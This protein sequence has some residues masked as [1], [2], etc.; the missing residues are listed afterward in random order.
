MG[1]I[2]CEKC[3]ITIQ[4]E[5][6]KDKRHIKTS[7]LRFCSKTC[8]NSNARS[9]ACKSALSE[10]MKGLVYD[11]PTKYGTVACQHCTKTVIRNYPH[12]KFCSQNCFKEYHRSVRTERENYRIACQ[13]NF[14]V[15]EYPAFFDL[16]LIN[17]HGWYAPT[18]KGNNLNGVSR[19]HRIS[20][21]EGFAKK[22]D[23]KIIAH[24]ANCR[25]VLHKENQMKHAKSSLTIEALC[26]E[27]SKF[28]L[29]G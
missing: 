29:N 7:S 18:N 16:A 19:D 6:R 17:Q 10:K 11:R 28:K 12:T 2:L 15:Y 27:I 13:F 5:W 4:G 25:L 9:A 21:A 23:P 3:N 26:E 22:I 1:S 24:P 20:I 14:N 8:A